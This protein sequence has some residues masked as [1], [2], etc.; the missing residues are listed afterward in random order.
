MKKIVAFVIAFAIG[1]LGLTGCG[2]KGYPVSVAGVTLKRAPEQVIALSESAASAIAALGYKSTLVAVPEACRESLGTELKAAGET[3]APNMTV[4]K[5]LPADLI[6]A[7]EGLN[8]EAEQEF[9]S[10]KREYLK[11]AAPQSYSELLGYYENIAKIFAGEESGPQAAQTYFTQLEQSL[12]ELKTKNSTINA[13]VL[14]YLEEGFAATGESLPGTIL[15]KAGFKNAAAGL[16][17]YTFTNEQLLQAKP[18]YIFCPKGMGEKLLK[19]EALKAVPAIAEGKVYEVRTSEV[20]YAG[21]ALLAVLG[22]MA[23][24]IGA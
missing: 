5:D 21:A 4:L 17:G 8:Y 9:K 20:V 22:D 10:S 3:V 19:N 23:N 15:E 13:T 7:G 24:Y 2:E 12:A 16:T 14:F 18:Q 1:L 11:L 6:I